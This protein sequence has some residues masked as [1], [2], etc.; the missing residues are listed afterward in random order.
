MSTM[1]FTTLLPPFHL[2]QARPHTEDLNIFFSRSDNPG[3][4]YPRLARQAAPKVLTP[5]S[6]P[7]DGASVQT[8]GRWTRENFIETPSFSIY[9]CPYVRFSIGR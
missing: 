4:L 1:N 6:E 3:E 2:P 7:A 8:Q 5:G 9:Q